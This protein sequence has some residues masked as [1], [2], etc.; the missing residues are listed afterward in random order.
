MRTL[1]QMGGTI[2]QIKRSILTACQLLNA[3]IHADSAQITPERRP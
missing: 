2:C 1:L 3:H